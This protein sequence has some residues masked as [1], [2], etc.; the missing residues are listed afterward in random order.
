MPDNNIHLTEAAVRHRI[1]GFRLMT[2][3]GSANL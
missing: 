1:G 3:K 2:P